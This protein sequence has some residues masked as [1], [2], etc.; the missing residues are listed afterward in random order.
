MAGRS[1]LLTLKRAACALCVAAASLPAAGAHIEGERAAASC[2]ELY[3][4]TLRR[5][6]PADLPGDM[7]ALAAVG[8]MRVGKKLPIGPFLLSCGLL[9]VCLSVVMTGHGVRAL[10]EA[11]WLR[12]T[13]LDFHSI[14]LLGIYNSVEGLLAQAALTVALAGSALWSRFS[15]GAEPTPPAPKPLTPAAR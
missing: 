4:D 6:G 5:F 11:G 12:L 14:S 2:R 15:G 9:L 3:V 10:Q 13:P 1:T 8:F 7:P